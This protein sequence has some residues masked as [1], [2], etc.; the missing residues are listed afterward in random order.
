MTNMKWVV[1]MPTLLAAGGL[2]GHSSGFAQG[3]MGDG[4]RGSHQGGFGQGHQGPW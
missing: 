2:M 1:A 3:M 4:A